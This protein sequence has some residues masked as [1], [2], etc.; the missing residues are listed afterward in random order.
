MMHLPKPTQT[1][2]FNGKNVT[3]GKGKGGGSGVDRSEQF[4]VASASCIA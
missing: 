2:F 4:G 1:C 3:Y